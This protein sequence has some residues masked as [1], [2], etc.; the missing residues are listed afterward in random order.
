MSDGV[1]WTYGQVVDVPRRVGV[2]A[3]LPGPLGVGIGTAIRLFA[4]I[5]TREASADGLGWFDVREVCR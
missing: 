4:A 3:L 1:V 2:L 5:E